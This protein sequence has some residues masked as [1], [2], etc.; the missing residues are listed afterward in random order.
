MPTKTKTIK[1]KSLSRNAVFDTRNIDEEARTVDLAFS[2][3]TP[4]ERWFGEEILDHAPQSVRLGRLT[5]GAP[6]LADHNAR[7]QIGVVESALIDSDRVGRA[8]VRFGQSARAIE[9]FN[10]IKD[11]IRTKISVGYRILKMQ[12]E[13]PAAEKEVYRA[14]DWEP[15]EVSVVSVAADDAVG[16]GRSDNDD[17]NEIL[18][19][20]EERK[21]SEET[22]DVTPSHATQ[23][24]ID[25]K[26]ER[27]AAVA[28]ERERT[29]SIMTLAREHK[30]EELAER[31]IEQGR[32]ASD[33]KDVVLAIAEQ[34]RS[35][36]DQTPASQ[37]D[38][39][40]EDTQRF[41]LMKA[42]R[43]A[44]SGDWKD[45][46]FERE[47]SIAIADAL[48]REARGFFVPMEVQERVMNV[49][50]GAD[51][52]ATDHLAG[53]F[54]DNLRAQSVLGEAGATILSGLVGNVDIPKKTGSAGFSWLA[55]DGDTTNTDLTLGSVSMSPKTIGGAVAISRRLMKQSSPAIESLIQSDLA[56]GA[57]LAIDI[58][59]LAGTGASNQPTGIVNTAGV[60]TQSIAA[61]AGTGYPTWAELVGFETAVADDEAL[62][63]AMRY[64]TTSA[65]RGGLKV[66]AK[67]AG[68]GLFL[69]DGGEANGYPVSV[70]N[71]LAAKQIVFGNFSDVLIGMWGVLDLVP[72]T[73]TKAA[74]GGLVL[75]A[76]QD[77]DVALRH[78]ESFCINA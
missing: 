71:Q 39:T 50:T 8:K 58:A 6:V 51:V 28:Q 11:G 66:T 27:T 9:I 61:S 36:T 44:T 3:E 65:I 41:S 34:S 7:D 49:T 26:S 17:E 13:D 78:P 29:K 1:S 48:G 63:G 47:C 21:M 19:Q 25:V 2:S 37:L 74:A 62:M 14:T 15:Y 69:L 12:L 43:A 42:I 4:V 30:Q 67:D 76:F 32:S 5:N 64:I 68:S 23:S 46:G 52:I 31:F 70:S 20:Y 22:N 73:A 54:I 75:R 72:D 57:A 53:S 18:I 77:V 40:P 60:N 55:D 10:D 56:R 38:L 16:I 33:F 45:A 59:G 24:T 35:V